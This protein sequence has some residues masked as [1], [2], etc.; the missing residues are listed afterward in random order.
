MN[1]KMVVAVIDSGVNKKDVI[2]KG[3]TIDDY[4]YDGQGFRREHNGRINSHGTEVI[5]VLLKEA[6]DINILSVQTL[7]GDNKCTLSI[8]IDAINFCIEQQVDVINLSLGSCTAT[9]RK[10]DQLKKVCDEAVKKGIVIFAADH[11]IPGM[12]SYPANFDNVIGVT[13]SAESSSFCK[14][15]YK[16]K[17]IKFSDNEVYI[18]DIVRCGVQKGNSF[19]CPYL[20]GVY[21]RMYVSDEKKENNVISFMD[22][23]KHF[24][25]RDNIEKIYFN[26]RDKRE[27]Y[28]LEKKKV[29]YFADDMDFNNMQIY[30]MYKDV[31]DIDTCFHELY[32]F[33]RSKLKKM[34]KEIDYFYIGS[35]TNQFIYENNEY[36]LTLLNFLVDC[37]IKV[38]T[39]FPILS[40]YERMIIGKQRNGYIKSVYK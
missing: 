20:A 5:K 15:T 14:V 2:F 28:S 21:C 18:P 24:I 40:T 17:V 12:K 22:F 23:L 32:P 9:A 7:R 10:I 25:K 33:D 30:G 8:I 35:L 26:K 6:P 37:Q 29:L 27:L 16:D 36:L 31:C 38:I 4:Y 13:T 3:K 11:N 34:V 39:I 19:L 1:K